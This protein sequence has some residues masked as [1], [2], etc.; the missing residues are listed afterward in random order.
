MGRRDALARNAERAMSAIEFMGRV[1]MGA[2]ATALFLAWR[3][4]RR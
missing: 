1:V 3:N 4:R 2:T